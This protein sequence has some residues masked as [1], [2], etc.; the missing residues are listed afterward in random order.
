MEKINFINNVTKANADTFNTMQDNIENAINSDV[1]ESGSNANGN[2][3]KYVDGT[4]ICYGEKN[5]SLTINI[6]WGTLY[7]SET[8]NITY[9]ATFTTDP[10]FNITIKGGTSAFVLNWNAPANFKT[11]TGDYVVVRP[12]TRA[13]SYYPMTWIAIGRWK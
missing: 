10:S 11:N 7:R 4:M 1:V 3:V 6:S 12:D 2:Y 13:S 9:P 8:F 5:P